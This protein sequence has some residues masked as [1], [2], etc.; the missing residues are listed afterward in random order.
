VSG[1]SAPL[2]VKRRPAARVRTG[3]C[4]F[5]RLAATHDPHVVCES[6]L[7]NVYEGFGYAWRNQTTGKPFDARVPHALGCASAKVTFER[8]LLRTKRIK[9]R[10][11]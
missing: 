5:A 7:C 10:D 11:I 4:I 9:A 8:G 1:G 6:W 2:S 3:V